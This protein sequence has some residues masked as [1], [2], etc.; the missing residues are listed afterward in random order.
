MAK[1]KKSKTSLK[2][3]LVISGVLLVMA[4]ALFGYHYI[5]YIKLPNVDL[6]KDSVIFVI[7]TGSNF[8]FVSN[9]LLEQNII[10]NQDSFEWL[11]G[12]KGYDQNVKP[13]R[14]KI[15]NNWSNSDLINH[16][17][18]AG[19]SIPVRVTFHNIKRLSELAGLIG[20]QI[21]ADST[22]LMEA[23]FN[24]E[25]M[26]EK[27][28]TKETAQSIFIPNTYE[29]YWNTSG[30]QFTKRMYQEYDRFWTVERKEL[31]KRIGLS[32][33]EV[34]TLA[35]IV[36]AETKKRDEMP[37]VAGLYINRLKIGMRLQSDPT[38]VFAINRPNVHRVYKADLKVESP[39][40]TY[41]HTGL[42]PGPIGFPSQQALLSVVNHFESNYLY[43]CA[44]PDYSGYHNF[45]KS[46]SQ[47]Q[48][49]AA[50]YHR[51]LRKEGI[52]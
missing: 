8:E 36:E 14:F 37:K 41:I 23:F 46:Y 29:L 42:P 4:G 7:P 40:N 6:E 2:S 11:A 27:G 33:F 1:K 35:S 51:F 48:K 25:W 32:P 16:I 10:K 15:E 31:A 28:L 44:K 26:K 43:M 13:G 9:N 49:Y 52:R 5:S 47:H 20:N 50:Q 22:E 30:E 34:S 24:E 17:R 12:V 18:L 39:Y 3:I 19:N 45:A 38:V 21:E